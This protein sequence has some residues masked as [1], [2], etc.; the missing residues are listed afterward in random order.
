MRLTCTRCSNSCLAPPSTEWRYACPRCG[1]FL[2]TLKHGKRPSGVATR[3]LSARKQGLPAAMV[4][5]LAV[6]WGTAVRGGWLTYR[7]AASGADQ[8]SP[9]PVALRLTAA[10]RDRYQYRAHQL[11]QD[12]RRDPSDFEVLVRLGQLHLQLAQGD[13]ERRASHLRLARHY[14]L[15]ANAQAQNRFEQNW[16][17]GLMDLANSPNPMLDRRQYPG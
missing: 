12:V 15:N 1:S 2:P 3:L 5:V 6:A 17:R 4:A 10:E 8:E 14:L 13:S 7:A 11:E 9:K 16:V